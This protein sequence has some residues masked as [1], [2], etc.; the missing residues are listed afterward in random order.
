MVVHRGCPDP[1]LAFV[2]REARLRTEGRGGIREVGIADQRGEASSR[3]IS[4]QQASGPWL[5]A[6]QVDGWILLSAFMTT[7]TA[8]SGNGP[9]QSPETA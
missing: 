1:A 7:A 3:L 4:P 9:E 6:M 8:Q 5:E 2:S